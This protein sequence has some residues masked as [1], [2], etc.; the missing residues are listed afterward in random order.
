V[1]Q[2]P[3]CVVLTRTWCPVSAGRVMV[4]ATTG[5]LGVPVKV[6]NVMDIVADSLLPLSFEGM[7]F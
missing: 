2:T 4:L 3:E 1:P 7:N 5:P 6:L